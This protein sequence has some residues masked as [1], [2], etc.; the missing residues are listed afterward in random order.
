MDSETKAVTEA[1]AGTT[2]E[3]GTKARKALASS[4]SAAE[5]WVEWVEEWAWVSTWAAWA[6]AAEWVAWES[7]STD[8]A[9]LA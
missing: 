2:R 6:W 3:P 7:A 5:V 1:K 4:I 8:G 9:T